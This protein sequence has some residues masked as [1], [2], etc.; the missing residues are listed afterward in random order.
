MVEIGI[1]DKKLVDGEIRVALIYPGT[2]KEAVS[3]LGH[4]MIYDLLNKTDGVVAHRF[5]SDSYFSIEEGLPLKVYD[6]LIA[7]IHYEPQVVRLLNYLYRAGIPL[8]KEKREKRLLLGGPGVWNPFPHVRYADGIF[9]GDGEESV[10][11][12]IDIAH[13]HPD[14]WK[15]TG[16]FSTWTKDPTS[17]SYHDLS[18]TYSH[19][20]SEET[21]YGDF[22]LFLE[23]TRG[24]TFACRFCLIG[25]TELLRKRKLKQVY[26][27]FED[28]FSRGAKRV[29]FFGS[30]VLAHPHFMKI[31][32]D[33]VD[34]HIPFSI[35]STRVDLID[36]N[37]LSLLSAGGVKT[38]TV[39][40]EV[41]SFWRKLFIAKP[42]P[43]EAVVDLARRAKAF[44]IKRL[45]L[46]FMVGFPGSTEEE[47]TDI[48]SMVK[49]LRRIIPVRG[50]VSI[51][52]PKP[53]T[54]FQYLPMERVEKTA[55]LLK[56][57]VRLGLDVGNPKKAALQALISIGDEAISD[58]II[59]SYR[60]FNYHYWIKNAKELG[61]D[62]ETYLYGKRETPWDTIKTYIPIKGRVEGYKRALSILHSLKEE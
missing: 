16:L 29:V 40:P 55:S 19:L 24:C 26:E 7:S 31:V 49:E 33:L 10:P 30:D 38:L 61:I 21:T 48:V 13:L 51:F 17:F 15:L 5:T 12:F 22:P 39:A 60:N 4:L 41:V 46:Y 23:L 56:P 62:V 36:D 45:K 57:L 6:I 8:E 44:G 58:L 3:S 53:Y 27:L 37:L 59:R 25:W 35:P 2:Y 14:D 18:Y 54:P 32:E 34:F 28:H 50:T 43:N 1:T 42:I 47:V 11:E 9:I 52:T 20:L